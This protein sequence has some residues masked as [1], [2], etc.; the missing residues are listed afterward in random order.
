MSRFWQNV[1]S[2]VTLLHCKKCNTLR[3]KLLKNC[4]FVT[5]LT[6]N[7]LLPNA[8]CYVDHIY[9]YAPAP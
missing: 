5:A 3:Y 8:V 9:C 7:V 6:C 2:Y 1:T 4:N